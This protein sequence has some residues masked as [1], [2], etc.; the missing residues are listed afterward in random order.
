MTIPTSIAAST[1]LAMLLAAT[2][3]QA[4]K[5]SA[6]A[7]VP[8]P[9]AGA[10]DV[11]ANWDKDHNGILSREEFKSGWEQ[12]QARMLVYK[13]R[14]TFQT[15]DANKSGALEAPE[16]ANLEM[17]RKAGAAAPPMSTFDANKNQSLDFKEYLGFVQAMVKPKPKQ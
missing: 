9:P 11:F 17:V 6:T 12:L 5:P 1:T 16:Y 13:L 3:T 7:A 8:A 4:Q 15:M 2:S 10:N 14:E